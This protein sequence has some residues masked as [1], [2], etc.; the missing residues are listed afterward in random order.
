MLI[1]VN[2]QQEMFMY[3][4]KS[5]VIEYELSGKTKGKETVYFDKHGMRE[6]RYR[7][8]QTRILGM[9]S[10]ENTLTIRQDSIMY[11]IDL[12]EKTGTR[13]IVPFDVSKMSEKEIKE[14][15]EWGKQMREDLGFEKTGEE[16]ILGRKCDIWEGLGTKIWIWQNLTLKTEVNLLGQWI[17]EATSLDINT[18][19]NSRKFDVPDGIEITELGEIISET[20][21]DSVNTSDL[22]KE[23]QQGI[24]DFMDILGVKK[25][26][27]KK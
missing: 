17:T 12:D 14:W 6:A 3:T 1:S 23:L 24:N 15:E 8:A 9:T 27:K 25:K 21:L 18:R 4:V 5:G 20:Q 7:V 16:K 19:I 10:T 13:Q 2:A 11:T 22:E 26:K